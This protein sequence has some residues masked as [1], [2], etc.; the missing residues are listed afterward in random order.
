MYF[1]S[2][3]LHAI[4]T[5]FLCC[6]C[7]V[8]FSRYYKRSPSTVPDVATTQ[9]SA[10]N[11]TVPD[12]YLRLLI[13]ATSSNKYLC[14]LLLSAAILDYP[15]PT[16][17]NWEA[18]ENQNQYI[19]HLAK[20]SKVLDHLKTLPPSNNDDLVLIVDGYDVW[21][22]LR[23]DVLVRRYFAVKKAADLRA[24][25][26]LGV[27]VAKE[28]D[29]RHTVI[30]GPDKL[31]W[32]AGGGRRPAC[33]AVPQS[34]LPMNAFGTFDDT[35]VVLAAKNAFQARARWL[36]S[37]TIMGTVS[38]V[39]SVFE[40]T[41][42][43]IN[44][45]H[46]TDSDQFYIANLFGEQEY[47]RKLLKKEP[48]LPPLGSVDTPT[49]EQGKKYEYHM[50]LDYESA[51][52]QN[53][54]YYVRWIA[55]L[56]FDGFK[57]HRKRLPPKD[58]HGFVLPE[59]IAASPPP[60]SAEKRGYW[61][62][63]DGHNATEV[64]NVT[65][66]LPL[67]LSWKDLPLATNTITQQ[68]FP[69]MHFTFEKKRR[70]Q[71]WQQMWY[72]PYVRQLLHASVRAPENPISNMPIEGRM[73]WGTE[74]SHLALGDEKRKSKTGVR[75]GAWSDQGKWVSWDDMCMAHDEGVFSTEPD[76][77]IPRKHH[78]RGSL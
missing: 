28:H 31:C 11:V 67:E 78:P 32:P 3:N 29:V 34:P 22:Q 71:W 2:T 20:V 17:I 24:D 63:G 45:N 62:A 61:V 77:Y 47:A 14:Q 72:Y 6:L 75:G 35:E 54:G 12:A 38:D 46:T 56:W 7:F 21:F 59:D 50:A 74:G 18:K 70:D 36:N 57:G 48:N 27:D 23:P 19:Q 15:A 30:F 37:G 4:T 52:F 9:R 42:K 64:K 55:W 25:S 65:T 73:W 16:L 76:Y 58:L 41:L 13:P 26:E 39:R 68:T 49:I 66:D 51:L 10:T 60:F 5:I 43:S 1:R 40:A 44:A 8:L 69:V 33:W 53:A